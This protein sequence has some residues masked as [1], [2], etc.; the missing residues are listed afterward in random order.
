M[1]DIIRDSELGRL[2]RLATRHA[3]LQYPEEMSTFKFP[4]GYEKDSK[5]QEAVQTPATP[6]SISPSGS[7]ILDDP[8]APAMPE[9]KEEVVNPGDGSIDLEQAQSHH[10][11][12]ERTTSRPIMPMKSSDGTILVDWYMTD[13]PENPQNWSPGKKFLVAFQINIYSFA[14]YLGSSIYAPAL[15]GVMRDFGVSSVAGMLG[16]ALYVL[17]YGIGPMLFSPLSEIPVIGRNPIYVWTFL[18][19]VILCVPMALV[20]NFA[21][22]LVLRLLVGFFG[23]PCLGTGAA[24]FSD[25]YSM[26]KMPHLLALWAVTLGPAL[27]PIISGFSVSAENWH[28]FAWEMLWLTGPIWILMFIS[29]PETSPANILLRRA[30]RLRKLTGRQDFKSQSEIDQAHMTAHDIAFDALIKP[31]QINLLDPAVA[32]TTIYT[33]LIYGIFYSFFESF[34]LVF[35][36]MYRFNLGESNLP[37]LSVV[38]ALLICIPLYSAYYLVIVEPRVKVSGFG[39]PEER[40]IPGLVATFFVPAG[41]FLFAWTARPSIHW[42]VPT[43]GVCLVMIGEY[44]LMQAIFLYLPFTYPQYA[45]SLFAANDFA[46]S[47]FA[48]GAT[49][50]S[51]PMFNSIGVDRGITLLGG[52]TVGCT[53]CFYILFFHGAELRKRSRFAVK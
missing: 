22:L 27:A 47:A 36:V 44:T 51:G 46:R 4:E 7:S 21:G 32:F 39:P 29:L 38:V 34:P 3:Y 15:G 13:D 9:T 26:V 11:S 42:T 37:F 33:A 41:L 5:S 28:W 2:I 43:I 24:T 19:F 23:S 14:L 30:R 16:L 20:D 40:L 8:E 17:A 50:F 1:K 18:I 49:I 48:A 45:A 53:I 12:P 52:L 35:P 25:M 6:Q 10:H 31:W